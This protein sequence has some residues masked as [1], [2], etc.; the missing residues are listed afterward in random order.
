MKAFKRD[1]E[2]WKLPLRERRKL[3]DAATA[4]APNTAVEKI[5]P[6]T[7]HAAEEALR[8]DEFYWQLPLTDR[9]DL[10]EAV[11]AAAPN[12]ATGKSMSESRNQA[13]ERARARMVR[14]F[15]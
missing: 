8:K 11:A 10:I 12:N 6:E 15:E 9:R 4:A 3:Y 7:Y 5:T 2:Y 13:L 14:I 1:K